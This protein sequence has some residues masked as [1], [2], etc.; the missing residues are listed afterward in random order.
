[1][2]NSSI[3]VLPRHHGPGLLEVFDHGGIVGWDK[4]IQHLGAAAGAH[5]IGAEDIFVQN[6]YP[7]EGGGATCGQAFVGRAWRLL[8]PGLRSL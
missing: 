3:L 5:T 2:A 4:V 1:M 8:R 7:T 6:R